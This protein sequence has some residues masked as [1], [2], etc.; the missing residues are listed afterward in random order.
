MCAVFL[1]QTLARLRHAK[2]RSG[3]NIDSTRTLTRI[4]S[5]TTQVVNPIVREFLLVDHTKEL[6]LA[7]VFDSTNFQIDPMGLP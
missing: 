6:L 5:E 4:F 2:Q 1:T 7:N 3:K